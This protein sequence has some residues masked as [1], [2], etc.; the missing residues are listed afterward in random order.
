MQTMWQDLRYGV[1]MLHKQ[2]SFTLITV[3]TLALGIGANT[4]IFSVVNGVLLRSLPYAEPE[5]LVMIKEQRGNGNPAQVT[6]A[7]FLDWRS[8]NS[9][10]EQIAAI[11][12]REVNLTGAGEPERISLAI[13]S[14]N[15][16]ELL[17]AKPQLGRTF[18]RD[19]EQAGHAP[20][21]VMSHGLWQR[22]FGGDNGLIGQTIALDGRSYT[23]IGI[24]PPGFQYPGKTEGWIAPLR[25]APELNAEMDVTAVRGFGYLSAIARLKPGVSVKQAQAEM[26]AI[27]GRL[28]QQYPETNGNRFN[29]VVSLHSFLVGDVKTPLLV[30]LGA[31]GCVLLIACANVANL[32]LA[33]NATR[34]REI[35]I[36]TALGASRS[37]VLRQLMTESLLLALCGGAIGCWLAWWGVDLLLTIAPRD[38]PRAPEIVVN[39]PVLVYMLALSVLTGLVSGLAPAWQ[40]SRME[41]NVALGETT[42]GVA[43]SARKSRLRSALIVMEVALSLLL[44]VGAGLLFRSFT[45]LQSI[46]PGFD[47]QQVL[48]MRLSPTG[49]QYRTVEQQRAFYEQV[50]QGVTKLPGVQAVG[51]INTLPLGRGPQAGFRIEGRPLVPASQLQGANNRIITPDYFRVLGIPLVQGRAFDDRDQSNTTDVLIINQTLA[52]QNFPNEDPIGKRISFATNERGQPLWFEIIGVTSDIRTLDLQ[53]EPAS[54]FFVLH[55]QVSV[56]GMSLVIRRSG[57]PESVVP[58]VRQVVHEIDSNQPI[59]EI[60]MLEQIVYESV[61]RPRFNLWLLG[62]FAGLALVLAAAGIYGVMSYTVS[63]RTHELGIRIALGAQ[64]LDVIKLVIVQALKLVF[65]GVL[66]G[67]GGALA[68]TRLMKTLLFGVSA[69]D[70]LTYVVIAL[71]LTI[72]ALL[73]CY[74]PARRAMNVDPMVA[75]RI[76]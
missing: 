21:V 55:R 36:R 58:S 33:R 20:V 28:R 67:L 49:E 61:A 16:F 38:L 18:R 51:A 75:L 10:F 32:F 41:T 66:I 17:G 29:R 2:R 13:A 46:K 31:V 53:N 39:V 47:P 72:V 43:G 6:P 71:L 68:L 15:L 54:D 12:T 44:L 74:V 52:R 19:E 14:A 60:R 4:A 59:S 34:Q 1:R 26:D 5:R 65:T 7:N 45:R 57:E 56:G 73:A 64:Q 11:A 70:P 23:V 35:A 37:R 25:L 40:I 24:A 30:L 42:R 8:Q 22:R 3:L 76:D 69:T 27:T 9:V 50:L 62:L 48:T 63:Q